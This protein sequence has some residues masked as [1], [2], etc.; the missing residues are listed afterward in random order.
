ML[1]LQRL[2]RFRRVDHS[3]VLQLLLDVL[4][5][6]KVQLAL[7]IDRKHAVRARLLVVHVLERVRIGIV[8]RLDLVGNE[9]ARPRL[10]VVLANASARRSLLFCNV[11]GVVPLRYSPVP[12][13]CAP[14]RPGRP[15]S[16]ASGE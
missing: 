11:R 15:P 4:P 14:L 3:R 9:A 5:H 10:V 7:L 13:P 12:R 16:T 6:L 2:R 8:R 1:R